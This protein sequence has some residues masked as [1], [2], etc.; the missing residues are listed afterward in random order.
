MNDH[1]PKAVKRGSTWKGP[2]YLDT[3][4][5]HIVAEGLGLRALCSGKGLFGVAPDDPRPTCRHCLRKQAK[6]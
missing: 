4:P 6:L 1:E 5:L 3:R 2:L